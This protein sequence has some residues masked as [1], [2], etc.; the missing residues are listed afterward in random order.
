MVAGGFCICVVV[1]EIRVE[2]ELLNCYRPTLSK[3]P[4]SA[5]FKFSHLRVLRV[6]REKFHGL[7]IH[8]HHCPSVVKDRVKAPPCL[9]FFVAIRARIRPF[10]FRDHWRNSRLGFVGF[11]IQN[12]ACLA[13]LAGKD[14]YV[15]LSSFCDG[16]ERNAVP[17]TFSRASA[18][19]LYAMAD[20]TADK[21]AGAPKMRVGCVIWILVVFQ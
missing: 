2:C 4:R 3:P 17:S 9:C 19:A 6:L 1:D 12:F 11:I 13:C 8:V 5:H 16:E 10:K 14:F 15:F 7:R 21:E 20:E 18:V